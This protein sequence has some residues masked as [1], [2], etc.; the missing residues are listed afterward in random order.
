MKAAGLE[1]SDRL[2]VTVQLIVCDLFLFLAA[3]LD[4]AGVISPGALQEGAGGLG[5]SFASALTFVERY[6]PGRYDGADAVRDLAYD[7]RC[8]CFTYLDGANRPFR[9]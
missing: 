9:A 3:A 7:Q 8:S 4:R 1:T 5:D 6:A 2:T